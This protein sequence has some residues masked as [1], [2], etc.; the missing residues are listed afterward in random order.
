MNF[1]IQGV[2]KYHGSTENNT[3]PTACLALIAGRIWFPGGGNT[4]ALELGSDC[5]EN[6]PVGTRLR[7]GSATLEVT[8]E[9]HNGC[10]KFRGR[11][12]ADALKLTAD[13]RFRQLHLRGIYMRVVAAGEVGVGDK[14][15]VL[16]RPSGG[17]EP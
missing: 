1:G 16:E 4:T 12:G 9:P 11:F 10:A 17:S 6:L 3:D 13:R 2:L 8:P 7:A 14:I 15:A 5:G